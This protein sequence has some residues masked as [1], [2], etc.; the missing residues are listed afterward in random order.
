MILNFDQRIF[1]SAATS[2]NRYQMDAIR[3]KPEGDQMFAT[4]T[5]GKI[6]ARIEV[7]TQE[8]DNVHEDGIM[9]SGRDIKAGWGRGKGPRFLREGPNGWRIHVGN[10][11]SIVEVL[12]GDFPQVEAV[13]PASSSDRMLTFDVKFLLALAKAAGSDVVTLEV[14]EF[15]H[16]NDRQQVMSGVRVRTRDSFSDED[17]GVIMPIVIE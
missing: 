4:A 2:A 8:G 16:K 6:L 14:P 10:S 17:L 1:E 13:I 3:F 15:T 7:Q 9:L 5:N 12:E 11:S